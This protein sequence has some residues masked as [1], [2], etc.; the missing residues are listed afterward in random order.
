M[1]VASTIS[2]PNISHELYSRLVEL[3]IDTTP[4]ILELTNF[5]KSLVWIMYLAL[6][7]VSL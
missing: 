3:P 1:R 5:C 7:Y 4:R 2:S 6:S